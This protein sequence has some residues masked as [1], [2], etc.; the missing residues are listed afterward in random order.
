MAL[1]TTDLLAKNFAK[2]TYGSLLLFGIL[3][4]T[5]YTILPNGGYAVE[6]P[7]CAAVMKPSFLLKELGFLS[8]GV[9]ISVLIACCIRVHS[10]H[11]NKLALVK[12]DRKAFYDIQPV[13]IVSF[14]VSAISTVALVLKLLPTYGGNHLAY[15]NFHWSIWNCI[16]ACTPLIAFS[17]ISIAAGTSYNTEQVTFFRVLVVSL[18]VIKYATF[19]YVTY[20]SAD[21]VLD[22]VAMMVVCCFVLRAFWICVRKINKVA[23]RDLHLNR[24]IEKNALK[25]FINHDN[26]YLYIGLLAFRQLVLARCLFV[27]LVAYAVLLLSYFVGYMPFHVLELCMLCTSNTFHV[28]FT[29]LALNAGLETTHRSLYQ[30]EIE[31]KAHADRRS[32]LRYVFHEVRVPL[33]SISLGI[34]LLSDVSLGDTD[35]ETV[36]MMR[37][38]ATFMGETLN[39]VLAIQRIE[40]GALKLI[41]KP[42]NIDDLVCISIEPF[43]SLAED[44]AIQVVSSI[45]P[46]VPMFATGD[47]YRLKHVLMNLISNAVKFS[48][49]STTVKLTVDVFGI[50][51]E[52][53][54]VESGLDLKAFRQLL[55][56]SEEGSEASSP[57]KLNTA[58]PS[59][60][61][62][63][64]FQCSKPSVDD[65]TTRSGPEDLDVRFESPGDA[66]PDPSVVIY[67]ICIEDEGSGISP[68]NIENLFNPFLTNHAGELKKGRGTGAGL[69][70]SNEIVKLHGGA[71]HVKSDINVGSIFTVYV[72]LQ[73]VQRD[74]PEYNNQ[75]SLSTASI[76]FENQ[77][78]IKA[79]IEGLQ[80]S[81]HFAIF[82]ENGKSPGNVQRAGSD[83]VNLSRSSEPVCVSHGVDIGAETRFAVIEGASLIRDEEASGIAAGG[84]KL[85]RS[86]SYSTSPTEPNGRKRNSP[87]PHSSVL[88]PPRY[89]I[90]NKSVA[91][92][93]RSDSGVEFCIPSDRSVECELEAPS[94]S[95]VLASESTAQ[96]SQKPNSREAD[97]AVSKVVQVGIATA[98][99]VD[100]SDNRTK[101]RSSKFNTQEMHVLSSIGLQPLP[102]LKPDAFPCFDSPQESVPVVVSPSIPSPHSTP[103]FFRNNE[104][105]RKVFQS[106]WSKTLPSA[107]SPV[108]LNATQIEN[109]ESWV[110]A[111]DKLCVARMEPDADIVAGSSENIDYS[112][113]EH[114]SDGCEPPLQGPR[115]SREGPTNFSQNLSGEHQTLTISTSASTTTSAVS[116]TS[117]AGTPSMAGKLFDMLD[118]NE[119]LGG[120]RPIDSP[121]TDNR[122]RAAFDLSDLAV[123]LG[124]RKVSKDPAEPSARYSSLAPSSNNTARIHSDTLSMSMPGLMGRIRVGS[125][126]SSS[127]SSNSTTPRENYADFVVQPDTKQRAHSFC[128]PHATESPRSSLFHSAGGLPVRGGSDDFYVGIAGGAD[129]ISPRSS[130]RCD[131]MP[132]APRL[133][134]SY[135]VST[136]SSIK[137]LKVEPLKGLKH[138]PDTP[139][140]NSSKVSSPSGS[141]HSTSCC[142]CDK[143]TCSFC[144]NCVDASAPTPLRSHLSGSASGQNLKNL[145]ISLLLPGDHDDNAVGHS[146]NA[147]VSESH[148]SGLEREFKRHVL[149]AR[150]LPSPPSPAIDVPAVETPTINALIVDGTFVWSSS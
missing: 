146:N 2:A 6:E 12:A 4:L 120:N 147:N 97:M 94:K 33:N 109:Y 96:D 131:L 122:E 64:L 92:K 57:G 90:N 99:V 80:S 72:P 69:A 103:R 10:Q 100:K 55:V 128:A 74:S 112:P 110:A 58:T 84:L 25:T 78:A 27:G 140:N 129:G 71:I 5:D 87:S 18:C 111:L 38:A 115:R 106:S 37:E 35:R 114:L 31:R 133:S 61:Y 65:D 44:K 135:T 16:V 121:F 15:F 46:D 145:G 21:R 67:Q 116:T 17:M 143:P 77:H 36:I 1:R 22:R 127:A 79:S 134:R 81:R 20:F 98:S 136:S 23:I 101:R 117:S 91:P 68:S 42:F 104:G 85:D 105:Q 123:N 142:F 9:N 56:H 32:F 150:G 41:A 8:I 139:S 126:A 30:W 137:M 132:P 34:E 13:A 52:M 11:I 66:R 19:Y 149:S 51:D 148:P 40:E 29:M 102:C 49:A 14:V 48:R 124:I 26:Q 76:D 88:L 53:K 93:S 119:V 63:G 60:K 24:N 45:S 144:K 118:S 50:E 75:Q 54:L 47:K 130:P 59:K 7:A 107:A 62:G 82:S 125:N 113:E 43:L 141:F 95:I 70:I 83:D 28:L 39:D 73:V 3:T 89:K 138:G 86:L 108:I